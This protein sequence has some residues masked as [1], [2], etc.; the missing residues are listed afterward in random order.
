[1]TS[2]VSDFAFLDGD[3]ICHNRRLLKALSECD[4]W[5]EFDGT[6]S[7]RHMIGGVANVDELLAPDRGLA[8]LT[9]RTFDVERAEWSIFWVNRRDGRME[10]PVVG[11]F[12]DGVGT[13]L[14]PDVFE[15]TPITV[16]FRWDTT[17]ASPRWEQAFSTDGGETWETNWTADFVRA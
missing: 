11:R 10:P 4:E 5:D 15:G 3:W 8:G 12:V 6:V 14:G 13:F 17:G 1:M 16:R 9:V 7:F 2:F